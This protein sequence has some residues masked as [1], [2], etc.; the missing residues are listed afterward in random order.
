M[1]AA[2]T[3]V[4]VPVFKDGLATFEHGVNTGDPPLLLP[5]TEASF[6]T[7]LSLRG[8]YPH[9]RSAFVT[10]ILLFPSQNVQQAVLQGLWQGACYY[11]PDIGLD[12]LV[13]QISGRLFTFTPQAD[14]TVTV[15]E[16]SIPGD[17]N[18][19]TA[20]QAWLWQAE[21]YVIVQNGVAAVNPIFYNGTSSVRSNY[22][23]PQQFSTTVATAAVVVPAAGGA[24]VSAAVADTSNMVVGDVLTFTKF[25]QMIVQAI[26]S[27]GNLTLINQSAPVGKSIAVGVVISWTHTGTELPPGR[28]GAYGLGRNWMSLV[29]GKQFVAGDLVGGASGT[30]ANNFR[31]AVLNITENAYLAGGGNFAVPGSYG[32]IRAMLFQASL[33]QQ[34]GQ[35]PL[36][37]VT[38]K[39]TFSCQAPVDRTTW[40]NLT[41]PILTIGM[42]ANGGLGQGSTIQV[43]GDTLM[44]SVDGV[45]SYI[46]A[47]RDFDT[48]GNAPISFEMNR[49]LAQDQP[50]L[51]AY[52][53]AIYF[54]NRMLM[55]VGP[56]GGPQGVYHKGLIALNFDPL[57]SVGGK[58]PSIWEGL[59]L[60]LTPLQLLVGDFSE[61]ERAWAFCYNTAL[62]QIE[63]REILSED[64]GQG[65]D[66]TGTPITWGFEGPM[67]F[68]D[69][70][71]KERH[72][73]ELFTGEMNIDSQVGTVNFRVQYRPDQ[74][75]GWQDWI[76]WAKCVLLPV[77]G[78]PTTA[79]YQPGFWAR[80]GLGQPPIAPCD[81]CNNRPLRT[82]YNFQMRFSFTGACRFL[83]ARFQAAPQSE[84][85]TAP[86]VCL[87]ICA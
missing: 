47:Q 76:S 24:T 83:G 61:V 26:P 40:Q 55:T 2:G 82:G 27:A 60:G 79:N 38:P 75:P 12:R 54:D 16:V 48:W 49:V 67:L 36:L 65:F 45:R 30:Q 25:G 86:P 44:R 11:H 31:D 7:N 10:R 78:D 80:M 3:N 46:L 20:P 4:G 87:P 13:A 73:K 19:A 35:G 62:K 29:D 70:T 72:F 57:S 33:N 66:D 58:A 59:W 9:Q 34:L 77:P 18:S 28:M 74:W 14:N 81:P 6:G 52:S 71:P 5:P 50:S 23:T 69:P 17:L 8:Y 1:A 42:L 39:A 22:G 85:Q 21:N 51:L 64:A 68:K 63:L 56:T 15:A 41:N 37:V 32:D 43:N 84:P 53:S